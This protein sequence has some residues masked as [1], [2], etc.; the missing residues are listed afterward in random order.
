MGIIKKDGKIYKPKHSYS[1]TLWSDEDFPDGRYTKTFSGEANS[2]PTAMLEA[3]K[4]AFRKV[5]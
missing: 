2:D 1:V 3:L 4:E 5:E